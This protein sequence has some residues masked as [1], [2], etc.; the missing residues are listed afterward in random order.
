MLNVQ[1][2]DPIVPCS[3]SICN[4]LASNVGD[5]SPDKSF[6]SSIAGDN[7]NDIAPCSDNLLYP[8]SLNEI[9]AFPDNG[10]YGDAVV[11]CEQVEQSR[12]SPLIPIQLEHMSSC[13]ATDVTML[14]APLTSRGKKRSKSLPQNSKKQKATKR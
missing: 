7:A 6:F 1:S 5:T 14:E 10:C 4:N 13:N 9:N 2:T 8:T 12:D 11:K 3:Q